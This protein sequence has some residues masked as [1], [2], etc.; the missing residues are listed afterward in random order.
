MGGRRPARTDRLVGDAR[1]AGARDEHDPARHDDDLG[2]LPLPRTARDL[3]R[4][5]RPDERRPRRARHRRR[6]VRRRAHGVR[7]S[8][9]RRPASGSTGSRTS[10]PSSP[11]CGRR[12]TGETFS[13]DGTHHSVVDSPGL[14]KPAQRPH[15]PIIIGGKGAKRTP[16]LTARYAD[17]FNLPFAD[18]ET[19]AR[20]LARVRAACE[21]I[22]RDPA[23]LVYSVALTTVCGADEATLQRRARAIGSSL[24]DLRATGLA[25][26]PAEVVDTIGRYAELGVERVYLQLLDQS[27]PRPPRAARRRGHATAV[28]AVA[29]RP[30]ELLG[31]PD[32]VV[33]RV[34]D[35]RERDAG[36]GDRLLHDAARR[37]GSCRR[38]PWPGPRRRRRT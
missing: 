31:Q 29:R 15:P 7:A 36:D 16:A 5:G 33:L 37:G 32:D 27:R 9:S 6:L 3:G 26:T 34:G 10:S 22:D 17:E 23:S 25:G 19:A 13:Y 12:R 11:A 35:Q 2:D 21:E 20:Q 4:A 38:S 24:D 28:L 1:R 8:R 30:S 18:L 14:P